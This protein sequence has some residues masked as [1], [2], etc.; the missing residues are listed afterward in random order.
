VLEIRRRFAEGES[1]HKIADDLNIRQQVVS[2]IVRHETYG[3]FG[4]ERTAQERPTIKINHKR[5]EVWKKIKGFLDYSASNEGRIRR[6]TPACGTHAGKILN[7]NNQ[8]GR[9]LFVLLRKN[10]RTYSRNVHRIIAETFCINPD[11][12]HFNI[13]HHKNRDRRCNK[14]WNLEWT[15]THLNNRAKAGYTIQ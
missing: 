12:E 9:Y 10:N 1:Q 15:D 2:K 4:G 14:D 6:D 5:K 11:P 13:V 3:V 7:P 8:K